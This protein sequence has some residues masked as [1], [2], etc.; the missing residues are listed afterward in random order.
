M[1][2]E[3]GLKKGNIYVYNFV[4]MK[5]IFMT[6]QLGQELRDFMVGT[7]YTV[8]QSRSDV[9]L[10]VFAPPNTI[11]DMRAHFATERCIIEPLIDDKPKGKLAR[12]FFGFMASY[13]MIPTETIYIRQRYAYLNGGGLLGFF[14]KRI[15]WV[16]AHM[17]LPRK[18]VR[19][20][21]YRFF[22]DDYKWSEYFD[23]YTPD[24]VFG[25]SGF[26]WW[27]FT[28][29][30]HAKRRGIPA[31]LM[32]RS[33]DNLSTKAFLFVI[34][35]LLLVQNPVM[36]KEAIDWHDVPRE[37]I[38]LVGSPPYDHYADP[39]WFLSREKVAQ[40]IGI[41]PSKH[42]IGY[43]SGPLLTGILECED[44]GEHIK[45][46]QD[47][48][49]DGRIKD[50]EI[51]AS[52][53]PDNKSVFEANKVHCPV[54][55]LVKGWKFD[56]EQTRLLASFI[57]EC[58]VMTHFGSTV[59]LDAAVLDTPSIIIGFNGH[60]DRDIPWQKKLSV[61]FDHTLHMQYLLRTGG[62]IRVS[63]ERE[64]IAALDTYIRNRSLHHDGR[65][66][67][68]HDL[69]GPVDGK[70]GERI[71]ETVLSCARREK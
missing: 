21:W 55:N 46:V 5:T 41:D 34:P 54:L 19:I 50:V 44:K 7:F 9:R 29:L 47:A 57:K 25:T 33:W 26:R 12:V 62:M 51:V 22:S 58:S 71:F 27:D 70:V 52:I 68:V 20:I 69:V 16:L 1:P 43:F 32:L 49:R 6:C 67:L 39:S 13:P 66:R 4:G 2:F 14:I 30:A 24:V 15:L 36:V 48:M 42:W 56:V 61:A 53:H 38:R 35:D 45:M 10:V 17:S 8:A 64:F 63:N 23:R 60:R 59:S 40:E 18:L 11:D 3:H 65:K 31:V 28:I 37:T